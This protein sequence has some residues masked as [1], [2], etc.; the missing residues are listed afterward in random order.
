[1]FPFKTSLPAPFKPQGLTGRASLF[2]AGGGTEGPRPSLF[3]G[4]QG[5]P[6]LLGWLGDPQHRARL[7]YGLTASSMAPNEA[8]LSS[9]WDQ[10]G[11]SQH[12]PH[13]GGLLGLLAGVGQD[14]GG[15]RMVQFGTP[16]AAPGAPSFARIF[17]GTRRY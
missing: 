9:L 16:T 8:L 17:E 14:Q 7:A 4:L 15:P 6:G 3:D 12:P 5:Q 1:M 11:F 10:A 13:A 2:G